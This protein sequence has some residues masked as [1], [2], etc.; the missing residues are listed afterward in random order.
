MPGQGNVAVCLGTHSALRSPPEVGPHV[1]PPVDTATVAREPP[2]GGGMTG[3][4]TGHQPYI[5]RASLLGLGMP[6]V[7]WTL[8]TAGHSGR[9]LWAHA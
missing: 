6:V 7:R 9:G 8:L 5:D 2:A 3:R 4:A 1:R